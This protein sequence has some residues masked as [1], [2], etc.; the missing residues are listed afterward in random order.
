MFESHINFNNNPISKPLEHTS[1]GEG[2][3]DAASTSASARI[4]PATPKTRRKAKR[5]GNRADQFYIYRTSD[6]Q[7]IP[8]LAIEY[9]APHKL[10]VD[11]VVTG[12]ESE[13]YPDSDVININGQGFA[14]NA[15]V[16][17]AA[18][19]TQLFSY[20]IG[21]S[22]RYGYSWHDEAD[23]LEIW[24][25][26]YDDI[27]KRIPVTD[28][29]PKEPYASPYKPQRWKG[30]KRS[31]ILTRSRYQ[32]D[33]NVG[34][35]EDD[36]EDDDDEDDDDDDSPSPTPKRPRTNENAGPSTGSG[37][38]RRHDG[39]EKQ[40]QSR[41]TKPSIQSRSYC[42]QQC[43][44]GLANGGPTDE[45]CPNWDHHGQRHISRLEFLRLIRD[46]LA[47]D[48]GMDADC[49][50]LHRTGRSA[51][52]TIVASLERNFVDPHWTRSIVEYCTNLTKAD[53]LY[54]FW[55]V[56]HGRGEAFDI[57][58]HQLLDREPNFNHPYGLLV[59]L[60][61]YQRRTLLHH[62]AKHEQYEMIDRILSNFRAR[63]SAAPAPSN[64]F[65][66]SRTSG[67]VRPFTTQLTPP[68]AATPGS[69]SRSCSS[70][71][72]RLPHTSSMSRSWDDVRDNHANRELRA[73]FNKY[74]ERASLIRQ[75]T[76]YEHPAESD[77][78]RWEELDRLP[79]RHQVE[80]AQQVMGMR[81]Q[82]ARNGDRLMSDSPFGLAPLDGWDFYF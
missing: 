17:T 15:R 62:A 60:V 3:S 67:A 20:M 13:I 9:K 82:H 2:G 52:S 6:G 33:A 29:K 80:H 8:A 71:L 16:L 68:A 37:G 77:P 75:R 79:L 81:M 39:G 31:L 44:L 11:Q 69:V 45:S 35:A 28:R 38:Q 24:P 74:V 72:S 56:A 34:P 26:E 4:P 63:P 64:A 12:L 59:V 32:P 66:T 23:R 42:T 30:F 19:V 65:S 73:V 51:V 48:R 41:A 21:K 54:L 14:F 78:N 7:N 40:G 57:K 53:L 25:V 46:Q 76:N 27:L 49:A 61:D 70:N 47:T 5:K 58:L 43:L 18:V 22:I 36:D 10:S 50:P 55:T 1:L